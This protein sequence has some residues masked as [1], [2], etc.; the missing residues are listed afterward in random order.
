MQVYSNTWPDKTSKYFNTAKITSSL[1]IASILSSVPSLNSSVGSTYSLPSA[2][3]HRERFEYSPNSTHR[4]IPNPAARILPAA[5][6]EGAKSE[7]GPRRADQ[8]PRMRSSIACARCRRS[9]VK[10][11]NSGV[12]T[13]CRACETTGRE[14]T[15]PVPN[16]IGGHG[17]KRLVDGG[18]VK[19]AGEGVL[20]TDVSPALVLRRLGLAQNIISYGDGPSY[21]NNLPRNLNRTGLTSMIDSKETPPEENSVCSYQCL[22]QREH[23]SFGG[24]ARPEHTNPSGLD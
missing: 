4:D 18:E 8:P 22:H 23:E 3:H 17:G 14:C 11:V 5:T 24:C 19:Y 15:Y 21:Q 9:K 13:Q 10:C 20:Q 6:T 12:G 16:G 7:A 2:A 1:P